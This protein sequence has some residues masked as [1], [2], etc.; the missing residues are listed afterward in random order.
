VSERSEEISRRLDTLES[1]PDL[2]LK[3]SNVHKSVLAA[4]DEE[5]VLRK[6]EL[7]SLG[8]KLLFIG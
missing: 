8:E 3:L 5:R 1:M 6:A 7:D 2:Q 4:L